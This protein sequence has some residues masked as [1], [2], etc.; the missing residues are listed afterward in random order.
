MAYLSGYKI[1]NWFLE[2]PLNLDGIKIIQT[3]RY[4]CE[5]GAVIPT[6][7]HEDFFEYT[8]ITEGKG[9][10]FTNDKEIPVGKN[11]IY[12][13]FPF[14]RHGIKSSESDPLK[15]DH[16]AFSVQSPVYRE[17]LMRVTEKYYP[18]EFRVISD[19]RIKYLVWCIIDEFNEKRP[20]FNEIL[21]NAVYTV[22]A[23]TVRDFNEKNTPSTLENA[24]QKEIF[25]NRIMN[26]I[27]TNIYDIENLS[28]LGKVTNYN[29]SYISALFRETTGVTLR[30]YYINRKLEIAD[31]L[32]KSGELKI[33]AIAEKLHYSS[34]N[35]LTKAYVK[36]Y[37]IPPK[38]AR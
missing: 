10:I 29:Y 30:D 34:G 5:R 8:I 33:N 11:D 22:I 25:C 2:K 3:G 38:K 36:K 32:I 20:F 35:A 23:Y 7:L 17:A 21:L 12:V 19:A 6:A 26:Y 4:F 9:T 13:S 24:T 14:D 37:G 18:P 15:Y 27:D 28:D 1:N 16:I 31:M